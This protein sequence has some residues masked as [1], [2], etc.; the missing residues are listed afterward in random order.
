MIFNQIVQN[1]N[2]SKKFLQ[3][4]ELSTITQ[5]II[6]D[7]EELG[8]TIDNIQPSHFTNLLLF[9]AKNCD[10]RLNK[11]LSILVKRSNKLEVIKIEQCKTLN[12][13]IDIPDVI[14]SE[15]EEGKYFTQIK[16]IKLTGLYQ[17]EDIWNGEPIGI[18]GFENLQIVHIKSCP[19]LGC[20][21]P[22]NVA[23]R[24]HQLNE[25]KLEA[26]QRLDEVIKLT[27]L[28]KLPL[29][30]IKFP[31]LR[32]VEFKSLPT[33]T[34]LWL[35]PIEFP[36]LKSLMIEKCPKLEEFTTGF[37]TMDQSNT[38]DGKSLFELNELKLDSCHMM[39]YVVFSKTLQEL[40]NLKKLN[41][42]HCK[43][44]EIVFNI[45]GEISHSVEL[46][47]HLDE[48]IL[49][50]LPKLTHII[51]KEIFRF[52]QNLKI[53]Q[54]KQCK[55]LNWLPVCLMLTNMEI[56]N[57]EALE[58]IM[59]IDKEKETGGKV[60]FSQLKNV[61]LENLIKISTAFPSTSEFPSL[62]ILK[63]TNCPALMTF[64]EESNKVKDLS[65]S[66]TS[67]YFFPNS[68]S[69][70]KLKVLYLINQHVQKLWHYSCP[71]KSF[72]ELE[73]LT[74]S[75]NNKLLSVISSNMI[76]RFNNL[77]KLT[78]E[79][80]ELL[81]EV[82]NLEDDKSDH[83][84]HEIL[85]QLRALAL[86]NLSSFTRV[87]NKEPQVSF[88]SNLVSLILIH[89]G[90]LKSLFSLS[91][92]KNLGKLKLLKLFNCEKLE[93]VISSVEDENIIFPEMECLILK[94]LPKLVSF[95][96]QNRTLDWPKLQIV[97][98]NNIPSM[99]IFS[100]SNL[101]TPLLRSIHITFAKKLWLGNLNETISYLHNNPGMLFSMLYAEN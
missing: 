33:L 99:K 20:V 1:D 60:T 6:D 44:L 46:M 73:N 66:T 50:D 30:T 32:K 37:A 65:K 49:I 55:S 93:E 91:S 97:R 52:C 14:R 94:K 27:R 42:T 69:L 68:L 26:C 100:T 51:N 23:K 17:L 90:S 59:I 2:K 54:V 83:N 56:S 80:C 79:K 57:C 16:E 74:L 89:C 101:N 31:A 9:Q 11:F 81:T 75:N 10:Q 86:S 36:N 18:F 85:P 71:C 35:Y 4:D 47:Q 82:F 19:F 77:K 24:L 25:L 13:L 78:L 95:C 62:E 43:A 72:C 28:I 63:I 45:H 48:L 41:V 64:V 67:N 53:L 29:T 76:I 40:S 96:H 22:C 84:I 7:N 34:Q 3:D 61:S 39:V 38:T 12:F 92:T 5:Y 21:F 70:D 15:D 87:W 8:K 58:K 98:V 88:F